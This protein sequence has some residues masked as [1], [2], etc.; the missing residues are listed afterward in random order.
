MNNLKVSERVLKVVVVQHLEI[1]N[2]NMSDP[3][4]IV[5]PCV[6][7]KTAKEFEDFYRK[8]FPPTQ[9]MAINIIDSNIYG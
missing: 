8:K 4:I 7:E 9:L 3:K 5:L 6:D 1:D 2:D